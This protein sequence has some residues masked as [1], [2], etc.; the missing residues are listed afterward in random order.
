M[1]DKKSIR[2]RQRD[3]GILVF[4]FYAMHKKAADEFAAIVRAGMNSVPEKLRVIYDFSQSPS[5]TPYFL[6]LQGKLYNEYPHPADEKSAYVT[7]IDNNE[8]WVRIVRKYLV[9]K[10]IMKVFT[11]R[12][13]AIK[14]LLE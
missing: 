7:G 1:D 11:M 5:P 10:D 3:D 6:T 2:V 13:D 4:E 14:W 9:A 8:V 12:E